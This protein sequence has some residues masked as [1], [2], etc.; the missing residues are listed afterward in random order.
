[1]ILLLSLIVPELKY[2]RKHV[3]T[4]VAILTGL[5]NNPTPINLVGDKNSQSEKF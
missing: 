2:A 3:P 5:R 1:M 4:A